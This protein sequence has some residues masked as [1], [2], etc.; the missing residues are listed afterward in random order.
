[1]KNVDK[2]KH[3]MTKIS[4]LSAMRTQLLCFRNSRQ[5]TRAGKDDD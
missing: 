1:M 4:I 2:N 3:C 5:R